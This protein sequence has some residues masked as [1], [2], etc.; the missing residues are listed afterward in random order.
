MGETRPCLR[1]GPLPAAQALS[2]D[3]E[4]RESWG[5]APSRGREV[6][7]GPGAAPVQG[8]EMEIGVSI[9]D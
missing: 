3:Q 6:G 9:E 7:S 2:K 5:S 4:G 1:V 8:S